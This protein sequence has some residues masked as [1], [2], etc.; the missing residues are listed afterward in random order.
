[1]TASRAP[2]RFFDTGCFRSAGFYASSLLPLPYLHPPRLD[3]PAALSPYLQITATLTLG[4]GL[5]AQSVVLCGRRLYRYSGVA[6]FSSAASGLR[7]GSASPL[8]V[9]GADEAAEP[10]YQGGRAGSSQ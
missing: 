6:L 3:Y 5:P 2:T 9:H 8:E 10:V 1:M 7:G 4:P